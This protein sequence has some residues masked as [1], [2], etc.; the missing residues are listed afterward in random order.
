MRI[1][2]NALHLTPSERTSAAPV[3]CQSSLEDGASAGGD[4]V[5]LSSLAQFAMGDSPK[6]PRLAADYAA[7]HYYAAPQQ[8]A[9]GMIAEHMVVKYP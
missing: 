9:M 1:E 2:S 3:D 7:G 6:V 5:Q 8:I 4:R